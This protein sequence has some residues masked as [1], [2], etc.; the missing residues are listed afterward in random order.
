MKY[1]ITLFFRLLVGGVFI[2]SGFVKL[3]D[4]LGSAYKFQ[5]YFSPDVLNLDFLS[6]YA[7]QFSIFLIIAEI[8]LGVMLIVGSFPKLTTWSLLVLII[9]FLYLTWYSAF[10]NKVTDCG[11]FGDAIKLTSWETFYKN[12]VLVVLII[13]L[14]FDVDNIFPIYSKRFAGFLAIVSFIG[15]VYIT[16]YVLNHLPLIDFRAYAVGKNIPDQMIYPEGAKEDVFEMTFIYKVNGEDK[17]FTEEE[18]PWEI[19]G[20]E[21]VDRK[22]VLVEKGYEPPI[23]DFTMEKNG[24]DLTEQ[25]MGLEKLMLIISYDLSKS[26]RDGFINIKTITD[27]ALNNGY[28]VYLMTASTQ[29]EFNEI[30]K[31]FYLEFDMLYCDETTLKTI[32]RASPGIIVVNKGTIEGKWNYND[33]DEV[34]IKEGMGRKSATLDFSLKASLDSVFRLDQKYRSVIKATNPRMRDSL[35]LLYDIPSDSLGV[36]FWEKQR[37]IDASNMAFLDKV[38]QE[39]GYPGRS[40]VGELSKDDAAKIIE[41]SGTIGKY[42]TIIKKAAE[43]NEMT[44]T[45]AAIMEDIY[46]MSQNKEQVYGTQIKMVGGQNI[47]W[48]IKN[49]ETLNYTRKNAGFDLTIYEY[50]K[51]IFGDDYIFENLS[52]EEVLATEEAAE[53]ITQ[54]NK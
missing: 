2:F 46:L 29:E 37:E 24:R 8:L 27:K 44:Y 49:F 11:C 15:F 36:D 21:Y 31:S 25:L 50:A 47:I 42:L 5:E 23:H 33:I 3:I 12:I 22:T 40:L 43:N 48:P 4:P 28:T 53:Q 1:F 18:K 9:V 39:Y 14:V 13:W 7:L 16:Y 17:E 19:E 45:K 38:I 10:F 51:A 26:D 35:M 20:A 34:K 52:L 30:K 41:H 6:P 54:E 32:V